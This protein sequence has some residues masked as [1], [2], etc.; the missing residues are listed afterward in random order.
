MSELTKERARTIITRLLEL[1]GELRALNEELLFAQHDHSYV[2]MALAYAEQAQHALFNV[3][4]HLHVVFDI[5]PFTGN[6][7]VADHD[8]P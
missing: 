8:K 1:D 3:R 5:D 6:D 7:K 2:A 4:N